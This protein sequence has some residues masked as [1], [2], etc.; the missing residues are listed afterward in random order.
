MKRLIRLTAAALAFITF[1]SVSAIYASAA[2]CCDD[3]R[4]GE[5]IPASLSVSAR[6]A[7]L[8]EAS[9]GD[10]IYEYNADEML[11]MASTT[12]IMTALV[13][14]ESCALDERVT[15][16]EKSVGIEGSSLYLRAG[17]TLT[18]EDLLYGL[19]L[20]SANDAA[21][22]LAVY[23]AGSVENFAALMNEK[24]ASLG[25][26]STH[27][28]NPHGLDDDE[29]RT[30]SRELAN[31]TAHALENETFRKIVSTKEH[32]IPDGDGGM[33]I[34]F[35]H[36]RLLRENEDVIGV[37]TGYTMRSGRCLVSAAE[38]DGVRVIAVTLSDPDDWNDHREMLS[39]G[40][41]A[42]ERRVLAGENSL[43]YAVPVTGG[44]KNFVTVKN[45]EA[46]SLILPA[47]SDELTLKIELDAFYFA[48]I[49]KGAV[50]GRAVWVDGNGNEAASVSLIADEDNFMREVRGLFE[51]IL[52]K[53]GIHRAEARRQK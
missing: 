23:C 39:Y 26:E 42:Y 16:T 36:N 5:Y 20:Q 22:A 1:I 17:E 19:L 51:K 30:T 41:D 10:V 37:K 52:E 11:L 32:E 53:F 3:A 8:I 47:G 45:A 43:V 28:T 18:V 40:L 35:N 6:S 38:R 9:T 34:L 2:P 44:V 14:L 46:V 12:K 13:V 29:H 48:P 33:R 24:A 7:I 15:I 21:T 31:I 50:L 4:D 49:K 27:F 25:C